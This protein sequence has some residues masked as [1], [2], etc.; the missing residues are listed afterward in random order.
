MRVGSCTQRHTT[1][2]ELCWHRNGRSRRQRARVAIEAA[3]CGL[4]VTE[5]R[6]ARARTLLLL[7][8][9]TR[10]AALP[11]M[12]PVDRHEPWNVTNRKGDPVCIPGVDDWR[13]PRCTEKKPDHA[14]QYW[15]RKHLDQCKCG[16]KRP[17]KPFRFHQSKCHLATAEAKLAAGS[18]KL[19]K[20]TPK[21]AAKAAAKTAPAKDGPDG[22]KADTQK[23]REQQRKIAALEKRAV[24]AEKARDAA[25]AKIP[26]ATD[27]DDEF[28][29]ADEGGDDGA[30]GNTKVWQA[31]LD[32][33]LKENKELKEKI[34]KSPCQQKTDQWEKQ[35]EDNVAANTVLQDRIWSSQCPQVQLQKKSEKCARLKKKQPEI[36][37]QI[38]EASHNQQT[39]QA[40]ADRYEALA[41]EL[42]VQHTT[43]ASEIA[44]LNSESNLVLKENLGQNDGGLAQLMAKEMEGKLK[45][46]D[47]PLFAHDESVARKK[48]EVKS[49]LSQWTELMASVDI[50][51][52]NAAD[53]REKNVLAAKQ[54][55]DDAAKEAKAADELAKKAEREA[56]QQQ[57][58]SKE[59]DKPAD[60]S[61]QQ[62]AA[63]IADPGAAAAVP[64]NSQPAERMPGKSRSPVP[65]RNQLGGSASSS[66]APESDPKV[67][68][69][70]AKPARE[71][72]E[73]EVLLAA[74]AAKAA[75]TVS[76][77]TKNSWADF[78][79][80][81]ME[82]DSLDDS[83][84]K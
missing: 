31:T 61:P 20:A 10:G 56:R 66:T 78:A 26:D 42:L 73:G 9:G 12:A 65:R 36:L 34:A 2:P 14:Q 30:A 23:E 32:T 55:A 50:L 4:P 21:A 81:E 22:Q 46:F 33:N 69:A 41:A 6:L 54:K 7:H 38:R 63:A 72:S 18:C 5:E 57:E 49:M 70:L 44:R 83:L 47:D 45:S 84:Q 11:D 62:P 29:D 52:S 40:E 79:V 74:S 71:R 58:P 19:T 43:N 75:K 27:D 15:V 24:D 67:A 25:L 68:A 48:L 76:N 35:I 80:N 39:M 13:C 51:Q 64:S 1:E 77:S 60:T 53:L 16:C 82:D 3:K 8:H 17:N 59:E 28:Q 37:E